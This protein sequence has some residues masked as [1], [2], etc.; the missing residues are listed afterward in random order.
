[1]TDRYAE[2]ETEGPTDEQMDGRTEI[3]LI[4]LSNLIRVRGE[5]DCFD[6][7]TEEETDGPTDEWMDG[8]KTR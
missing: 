5:E 8:P 6:G 3:P 1:M 7:Y 2:E 4:T